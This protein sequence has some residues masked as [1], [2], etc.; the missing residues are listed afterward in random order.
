MPCTLCRL[1]VAKLCSWMVLMN[2]MHY[3]TDFVVEG[4][5][6]VCSGQSQAPRSR[7]TMMK[8]RMGSLGLFLQ[9]AKSLL[10][11]LVMAPLLQQFLARVVAFPVVA[12]AICLS[13]TVAVMPSSAALTGFTFSVLQ[14]LP[15]HSGLPLPPWES[16]VSAEDSL[17]TS[18]LPGPKCA[19][20]V[21]MDMQGLQVTAP[22]CPLQ[23]CS[24]EPPPM[25]CLCGWRWSQP[26]PRACWARAPAWTLPS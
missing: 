3:Y 16:S 13:P 12:G 20:D 15:L 11:S 1:F 10:F 22:C 18:F 23:P 25:L 24:A 21:P 14:T 6:Q 2:F 4:L 9:C 5:Y 19:A 8:V 7:D 26:R 17:T